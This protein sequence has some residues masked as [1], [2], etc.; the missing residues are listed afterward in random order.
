MSS[1][2]KIL[3]LLGVFVLAAAA[4]ISYHLLRPAPTT[5]MRHAFKGSVLQVTPSANR[6]TVRN[7]DM[8]GIMG[9]MVMDYQVKN[10]AELSQVKAGDNIEA[11]LVMGDSYW[12]EN[13]KV[14]GKQ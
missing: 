12:L 13:I 14:V 4:L 9:A 5:Q 2:K 11:T 8:P 7:E 6:I 10:G 1:S 3:A